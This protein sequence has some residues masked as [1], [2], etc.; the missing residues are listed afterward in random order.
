MS[1]DIV[2][3]IGSLALNLYVGLSYGR[4]VKTIKDYALGRRN[5]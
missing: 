4:G 1:L 2:I 5:F 3:F